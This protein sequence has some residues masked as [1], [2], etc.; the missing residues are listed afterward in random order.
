MV[1]STGGQS[2]DLF[3]EKSLGFSSFYYDKITIWHVLSHGFFHHHRAMI[4]GVNTS[5]CVST[6]L[7]KNRSITFSTSVKILGGDGLRLKFFLLEPLLHLFFVEALSRVLFI[8]ESWELDIAL[9][10]WSSSLTYWTLFGAKRMTLA[11]EDPTLNFQSTNSSIDLW[12]TSMLWL[13]TAKMTRN[14]EDGS[15]SSSF[16]PRQPTRQ[17]STMSFMMNL[18]DYPLVRAF[19]LLGHWISLM[20]IWNFGF[21]WLLFISFCT[22]PGLGPPMLPHQPLH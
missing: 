3:L 19:E 1:C 2:L 5:I 22:A 9:F 4:W 14:G 13:T 15:Q 6:S 17:L 20:A 7:T 10:R 21:F 8:R 12:H 11:I 18:Y 16:W